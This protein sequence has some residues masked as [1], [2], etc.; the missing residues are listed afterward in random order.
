M[1]DRKMKYKVAVLTVSDK[2]WRG[3]RRDEAGPLVREMLLSAGFQV[4]L[5]AIVPDEMDLIKEKLISYADDK[6]FALVVTTG[7][8]GFAPRDITPEAT[9]AVCDKLVPGIPEMMRAESMKIT[10]R[11][12][13]SRMAAGIRKS[14]LIINLPGS[15]KAAKENLEVVLD[16]I[17]H[18]LDLLRGDPVDCGL[19]IS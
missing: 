7:G 3:E 2:G 12:I 14:S 1:E 6:D 11:A 5:E 18:G 4:D 8:T 19:P 17:M 10:N 9:I 16:P 15:P 13:L